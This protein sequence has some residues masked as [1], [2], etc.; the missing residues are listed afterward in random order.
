M[1]KSLVALA[2]L[3]VV[4]VASAQSSVTLFG[5]VD[6]GLNYSTNKNAA[7]V[8]AKRTSMVS[9]ANM[10]SRF[11]MRGTEDLGGGLAASFWLEAGLFTDE[12]VAGASPVVAGST[13]TSGTSQLF[14]RRSTVSLSG[15]F[16]E[17]RLGRDLVA[18][19]LNDSAADPFGQVGVGKSLIYA[20]SNAFTVQQVDTTG[21]ADTGGNYVRSS[22]AISYIL[23]SNLGGFY[24]Q[25]MYGLDEKDQISNQTNS[26]TGRYI[27]GRAGYASG[28][29]NVAASY[30][31]STLDGLSTPVVINGILLGGKNKE[32]IANI[33]GTYDFGV[34]KLWAEYG[35]TSADRARGYGA[36]GTTTDG[37][38]GWNLA[39]TAPV[40]PG[41][42]KASY[43]RVKYS[44]ADVAPAGT[45]TPK[46]NQWSLGYQYDLSKRTALYATA[47]RISNSNGANLTVGGPAFVNDGSNAKTSTGYDF[48]LR[49]S[50]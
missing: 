49:H 35:R 9:G 20:A 48:G 30:G 33:F 34:A 27:G 16:G 15:N 11:G 50:F 40:G 1:K 47:S 12:G 6:T 13:S 38:S 19:Y 42:I 29:V 43:G 22:N 41:T 24:G 8:T 28:P 32:S 3:A 14:N 23:P 39:V 17:V 31:E 46:V 18:T 26:S 4:G 36:L 7:G 5:I 21:A 45:A 25:L 2:A 37:V 44:L 10:T